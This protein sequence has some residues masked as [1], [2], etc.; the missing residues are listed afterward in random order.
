MTGS[1]AMTRGGWRARAATVRWPSASF[2]AGRCVKIES[3]GETFDTTNPATER[4][5]RAVPAAS[6]S[7]V[8][9]AVAAARK[10]FV[11]H[12]RRGSPGSRKRVLL[13][14]ADAID[15]RTEEFALLD[16]LEMGRPIV[17]A[18]EDVGAGVSFLRY[19][20]EAADKVSGD[21]APGD[22]DSGFV[23][24]LLEPWGVVGAIVPWNFPLLAA[25]IAVAPALAAGNAVVLKPSEVSPSSALLLAEVAVGAGLPAGVLNVVAGRGATTGAALA[26]HHD[27][28][29]LHF[30]GSA[31]AGR[32]VLE[33]AARSNAKPVMLE[34]GGKSAQIVFADAVGID[35]LA[36]ALARAAFENSGQVCVA[37]SRLLVES[38]VVDEVVDRLVQAGGCFAPADPLEEQTTCGP[39]AT[40]AQFARVQGVLSEARKEGASVHL[41]GQQRW[42]TGCYALPAVVTGAS[43]R[44]SIARQE[45]FGPA[46]SVHPFEDLEEALRIAND[47]GYGLAATVWTRDFSRVPRLARGLDAGRIEIRASCAPSAPLELFSAEPFGGSGHGVLGGTRGLSTYLRHKAVE[48]IAG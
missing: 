2:I 20:A 25:C 27:V 6:P 9:A 16:T 45:V 31:A 42:D 13:A 34:L 39:L 15:A 24:G 11:E 43:T 35:G 38:R 28:D 10:A 12:W 18:M 37:R 36:E 14:V 19:Y 17:Q 46:L 32:R 21:V 26:G 47:T 3:H 29:K 8:D 40:S 7:Q 48:L 22:P 41:C 33:S 30:T 23:L 4:V 1:V 5:L 44:S